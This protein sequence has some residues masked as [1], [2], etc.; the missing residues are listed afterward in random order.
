MDKEAYFQEAMRQ[1]NDSE[2]YQ[3]LVKD[4]TRDM[5]KKV[6]QIIIES[7]RKGNIDDKTKEYL[8]APGEE[9]EGR[10]YLLPKIHKEGFSGCPVIS[11]CNTPTEKIS[12]FVNH[13]LAPLAPKI[14]SYIKDTN[15]FLRKLMA[16]GTLP[17]GATLCTV[18]VVGLYPHIPHDEGLQAVKEPLLV[19]SSAYIRN[20]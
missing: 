6:N 14:N 15:D 16:I 20:F 1:F 9:R 2:I 18:D 5:I 13:L 7:H 11:G 17:E 10:F 8:L 3:P 12:K 19:V 4:P